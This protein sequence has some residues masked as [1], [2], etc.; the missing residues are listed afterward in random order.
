MEWFYVRPCYHDLDQ[1]IE[2]TY[3]S[4]PHRHVVVTG[5]PGVGK[6][7]FLL[8]EL[9]Q[10]RERK[11]DVV[12][13]VGNRTCA[14]LSNP[15]AVTLN[16]SGT[17]KYLMLEEP[18]TMYFYDPSTLRE[19]LSDVSRAMVVVFASTWE[20]NYRFLSKSPHVKLFMPIWSLE[21]LQACR[22]V[23]YPSTSESRGKCLFDKWGGS[24][25]SIFLIPDTCEVLLNIFL[26]SKALNEVIADMEE[27]SMN[28][29][30]SDTNH[31]LVHIRVIDSSY[32]QIEKKW[33]SQYVM[34]MVHKALAESK[35][36]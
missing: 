16:L 11:R 12:V 22:A 5:T 10:A 29:R 32:Q 26:H 7:T 21:E 18:K 20:G 36:Y 31:W 28:A 13:Q 30:P 9:I 1:L 4:T 27:V 25:R 19:G 17:E 6:S 15:P 34:E 23:C 8:Y 2:D 24:S 35:S 3:N 14:F 33:P